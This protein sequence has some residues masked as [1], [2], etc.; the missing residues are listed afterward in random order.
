MIRTKLCKF[1]L[2]SLAAHM[3]MSRGQMLRTDAGFSGPNGLG[4]WL[5]FG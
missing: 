1:F 5:R 3:G 2:Y 4:F